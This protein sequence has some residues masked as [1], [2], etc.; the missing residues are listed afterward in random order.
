[1]QI[2]IDLPPELEQK[3][4]RQAAQE[5]ISLQVLIL[6]ALQQLRPL[7][8]QKTNAQWPDAI[9]SFEGELDIP[10]FE[11]YRAELLPPKELELF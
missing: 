10:D 7:G 11:S 1:M 6:Q 2:T 3:L 4:V 9:L 5:N 8:S